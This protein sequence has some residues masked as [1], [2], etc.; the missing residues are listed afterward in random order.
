M[1]APKTL[2]PLDALAFEL[3]CPLCDEPR[4]Y[5]QR[6]R[7]FPVTPVGAPAGCAVMEQRSGGALILR[8]DDLINARPVEDT[9]VVTIVFGCTEC[10]ETGLELHLYTFKGTSWM[11]WDTPVET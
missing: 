4:L 9:P 2:L 10:T 5:Q 8:E 7:V 3:N 1:P 11:V 6:V